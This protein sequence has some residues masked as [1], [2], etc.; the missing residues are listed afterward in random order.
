MDELEMLKINFNSQKILC[1][2]TLI[3]RLESLKTKLECEIEN[4]KNDDYSPSQSGI[5]QGEASVIDTLA[6]KLSV[7]NDVAK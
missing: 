6:C 5:I 1:K 4:L 7:L 3:D 2:N